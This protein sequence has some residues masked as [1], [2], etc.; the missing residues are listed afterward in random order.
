[1]ALLKNQ[2]KFSKSISI[3]DPLSDS[4]KIRDGFYIETNPNRRIEGFSYHPTTCGYYLRN[5]VSLI[6]DE[7]YIYNNQKDEKYHKMY[8]ISGAY[9][10][11]LPKL[12]LPSR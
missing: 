11:Q 2:I 1:M 6:E 8:I 9:V 3:K 5:F 12:D 4:F 10:K 7:L